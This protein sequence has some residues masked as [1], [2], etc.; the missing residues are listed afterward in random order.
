MSIEIPWF[1]CLANSC[2]FPENAF[3]AYAFAHIHFLDYI[4][5][6]YCLS[7]RT[8]WLLVWFFAIIYSFF[9]LLFVFRYFN[10]L[11]VFSYL[12]SSCT[13]I[14]LLS[15]MFQSSYI[16]CKSNNW[17]FHYISWLLHYSFPLLCF[18]LFCIYNI[19]NNRHPYL[20]SSY[21]FSILSLHCLS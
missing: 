2:F 12:S 8:Y 6:S 18:C 5:L 11:L 3:L 4:F 13:P 14:S 9:F 15:Y 1:P 17:Y 10:T 16:I 19:D 7:S 21:L 20:T